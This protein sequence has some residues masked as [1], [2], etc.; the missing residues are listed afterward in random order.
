MGQ[1]CVIGVDCDVKRTIPFFYGRVLKECGMSHFG[2][3][4]VRGIYNGL[5][6]MDWVMK[7]IRAKQPGLGM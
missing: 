2:R 1:E 5:L 4:W 3:V 6:G 7:N